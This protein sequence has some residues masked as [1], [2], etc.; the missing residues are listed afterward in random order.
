MKK[1]VFRNLLINLT[2]L[3]ILFMACQF[4]APQRGS[5]KRVAVLK[6]EGKF[7]EDT[8]VIV[9]SK[10]ASLDFRTY[11]PEDF[12]EISC[13]RVDD[14]TKGTMELVR[15]Q[16]EAELTGDWSELKSHVDM[17]M[18]VNIANFRRILDLRLTEKNAENVLR[19]IELL[20]KREDVA[21]A[22]P[23]LIIPARQNKGIYRVPDYYAGM[24][25]DNE[26]EEQDYYTRTKQYP[27]PYPPAYYADQL[28]A[29][30]RIKLPDAWD[31]AT[32]D[33]SVVVGV[34]DTGI[35]GYNDLSDGRIKW[36]LC[37]DFT[38]GNSDGVPTP[39]DVDQNGKGTH[40]AGIVGANGMGG[41]LGVCWEVSLV[42]LKVIR[43][44]DY[45]QT[46]Y[47]RYGI[48]Y[49]TSIYPQIP[50]LHNSVT[51][52]GVN[53]LYTGDLQAAIQ[54]YPGLF[55]C[56]AGD[57]GIDVGNFVY[58]AYFNNNSNITNMIV[59]G[60]S[61]ENSDLRNINS[62]YGSEVDLFAPGTNILNAWSTDRCVV[63]YEDSVSGILTCEQS[64]EN[65]SKESIHIANGYHKIT[66]SSS[67]A[68]F[69]TGV[70]AL[71]MAE[72]PGITP[73][74]LKKAILDG[75][76]KIPGLQGYCSTGGR[77]NAY[78]ALS[79]SIKTINIPAIPGVTVP[80][81]G[82]TPVSAISSTSQYTGTVTWNPNHSKFAANTSYTATIVLTPKPGYTLYGVTANYFTVSG[83]VST[84]NA[85]ESGVVTAVFPAT[86]II[87]V[88][89]PAIQGIKTPVPG[90]KP[91]TAIT[92]TNQYTGTVAWSPS[93]TYFVKGT[94]YTATITLTAN[95]DYT[96]NSVPA[97]YF[98]VAGTAS[99]ANSA[100]SGV[101]TAVF[102]VT[103]DGLVDSYYLIINAYDHLIRGNG[104][105]G[106][107]PIGRFDLYSTG[108]W[109]LVPDGNTQYYADYFDPATESF[110]DEFLVWDPLPAGI[111]DYLEYVNMVADVPLTVIFP[112]FIKVNGMIQGLMAA[113]SMD[114]RV[115]DTGVTLL[116]SDDHVEVV[117]P[118]I[119]N[120]PYPYFALPVNGILT[121]AP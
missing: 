20:G 102:P 34:L 33:L 58:P 86:V 101:V 7:A 12:P 61:E 9:L 35:D 41:V 99:T 42:S 117:Q 73:Q 60:M 79:N 23:D 107:G 76:D 11:T 66:G 38:T 5:E 52:Y 75:V 62:N 103:A 29:F 113:Y 120:Q 55:I 3:V 13:F 8:V 72:Y 114:I 43:D 1:G 84:S 6:N 121:P 108:V 82:S 85:A 46:S 97:N 80:K 64:L 119:N 78:K 45:S 40:V 44:N 22:G 94:Q 19:A 98:T 48:D 104:V 70:A 47:I 36:S 50:I 71:I 118:Y 16:I 32:G 83:S 59:V 63:G 21:Y 26:H 115:S 18:L 37:R 69:V 88:S 65:G 56:S 68:A 87:P 67:A 91:I 17:G 116:W 27:G 105:E 10:G 51:L 110:F 53:P 24:I 100:G 81:T 96:F 93:D 39:Y 49:A 106:Y 15:K 111:S 95:L 92:A 30:N 2:P 109:T 4:E 14:S 90:V 112:A 54:N 57:E 25:E 74:N 89:I 31:I 77:L 28:A